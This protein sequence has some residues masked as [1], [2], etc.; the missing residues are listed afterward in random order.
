MLLHLLLDVF[1]EVAVAKPVGRVRH[2]G[3]ELVGG[4]VHPLIGA[5]GA[6]ARAAAGVGERALAH[7]A[8]GTATCAARR[9]RRVRALAQLV[10]ALIELV[11]ERDLEV[12]RALAQRAESL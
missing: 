12:L 3:R 10:G 7:R 2:A 11:G 4:G 6:R 9:R 1:L 8:R 5:A